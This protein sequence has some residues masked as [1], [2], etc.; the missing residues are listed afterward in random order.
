MEED[1]MGGEGRGR[2]WSAASVGEPFALNH[3]F[4]RLRKKR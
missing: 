4:S 1:G 3:K 2:T